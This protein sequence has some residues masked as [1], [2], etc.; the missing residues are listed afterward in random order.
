MGQ[1]NRN[2][3]P[4][5]IDYRMGFFYMGYRL[6]SPKE[7]VKGFVPSGLYPFLF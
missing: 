7:T 4:V 3:N 5:G 6:V 2:S 1:K